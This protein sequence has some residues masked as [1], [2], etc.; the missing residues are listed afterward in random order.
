MRL[1]QG[2]RDQERVYGDDPVAAAMRWQEAG[3][4]WVHVVDLDGAFDGRPRNDAVITRM[5]AALRVPVEVGGGIRDLET[6]RRYLEAGAARVILGTA[7]A[8][9]PT[10]CATRVASSATA[11]RLGST[12]AAA[13]S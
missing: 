13:R 4:A 6:M 5:I 9:A 11:W 10:C 8:S 2:V 1:V 3:A 7:A 12:R